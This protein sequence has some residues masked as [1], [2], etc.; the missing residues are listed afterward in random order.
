MTL[1]SD[2]NTLAYLTNMS[3][4]KKKSFIASTTPATKTETV[5]IINKIVKLLSL[6]NKHADVYAT[7]SLLKREGSVQLTS[8]LG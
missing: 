7:E 6:P 4:R 3:A 2:V 8:L 5:E 1:D